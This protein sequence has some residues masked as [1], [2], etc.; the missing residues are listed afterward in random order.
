[1]SIKFKPSESAAVGSDFRAGE[2]GRKKSGPPPAF[3]GAP[4]RRMTVSMPDEI[5]RRIAA[6]A[7]LADLTM[8]EYLARKLY[9]EGTHGTQQT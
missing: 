5:L 4:L 9:G 3:N 6:E 8:G 1:M 2:T 7:A